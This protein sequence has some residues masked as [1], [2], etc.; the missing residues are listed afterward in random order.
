[1]GGLGVST[2][3][4]ML[5]HATISRSQSIVPAAIGFLSRR[6]KGF[7]VVFSLRLPARNPQFRERRRFDAKALGRL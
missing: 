3:T 2:Q 6:R 1:M 5:D 7:G 4:L